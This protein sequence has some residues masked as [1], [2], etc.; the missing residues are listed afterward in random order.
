M[1]DGNQTVA[2]VGM[3]AVGMIQRIVLFVA[4]AAAAIV[5]FVMPLMEAE[6]GVM[7]DFVVVV[8]A[9]AVDLFRMYQELPIQSYVLVHS[10]LV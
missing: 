2:Y 5:A 10:A 6:D 9:A 7:I 1:V 3:V 4:A 8:A